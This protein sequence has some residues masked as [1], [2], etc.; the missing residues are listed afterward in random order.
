MASEQGTGVCRC[1][2]VSS[3]AGSVLTT[4]DCGPARP[5]KMV[6]AQLRP[7]RNASGSRGPSLVASGPAHPQLHRFLPLPR[8]FPRDAEIWGGLGLLLRGIT[9]RQV[10][11]SWSSRREQGMLVPGRQGTIDFLTAEIAGDASQDAAGGRSLL[12]GLAS[13]V[14]GDGGWAQAHPS[15][16]GW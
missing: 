2:S 10:T 3:E 6:L 8:S 9:P 14:R 11:F 4:T 7:G 16:P 12:L 13:E 15:S 1:E 5:V